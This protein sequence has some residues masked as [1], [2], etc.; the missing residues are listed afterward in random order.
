MK[1][2]LL[3]VTGSFKPRGAITRLLS[4]SSKAQQQGLTAVSAGNHAAAVAYAAKV[5]STTAKVVMPRSANPARIELCRT[6]G[7]DVVITETVHEA[8]E[9]V[10]LIS[11]DENRT[12][13]HPFEGQNVALGTATIALEFFRRVNGSLDAIIVPVGGGGLISGICWLSKQMHPQTQVF[14]VEPYGADSLYRSLQS[15]KPEHL[16]RVDTIADSL[17]S[18]YASESHFESIQK[19]IDEVVRIDDEAMCHAM[20]LLFNKAKLAVEPAGAAA[21]AALLG[22]LSE[23]LRGKKVGL[24]ICGGNIDPDNFNRYIQQGKRLEERLCT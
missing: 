17:G 7:A 20:Y 24:V 22:P 15:G 11:E 4:M 23:R 13:V 5:F 9:R 1:L 12:V 3:Q 18:P 21:T 8:F 10:L 2:E 16:E 19:N 6:L 14:A